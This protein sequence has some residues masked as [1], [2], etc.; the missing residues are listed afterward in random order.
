MS[1]RHA[2][3]IAT[4][5]AALLITTATTA[6]AADAPEPVAAGPACVTVPGDARSA[7]VADLA[8]ATG[9]SAGDAAVRIGWQNS[10]DQLDRSA[11]AAVGESAYGGLWIDSLTGRIKL[12]V[13]SHDRS[14]RLRSVAAGCGLADGVDIVKVGHSAATLDAAAAWLGKRLAGTTGFAAGID[15]AR[16][17]VELDAANRPWSAAERRLVSDARQTWGSAVVVRVVTGRAEPAACTSGN[18]CDP[19]LRGGIRMYSATA[20]CTAGFTARSRSDGLWYVLTAGHC[21]G[22]T[23]RTRFSNGT[24]HVIGPWHNGHFG[25]NGDAQ[26]IRVNNPSGWSPRPWVLVEASDD[27]TRDESYVISAVRGST[28]GQRI[29]KTGYAGSTDCGTV[30]RLGVTVNYSGTIVHGLGEA[31]FCVIPGD[32]GGPVYASHNAYGLVSGRVV[33]ASPCRSFYQ[34]AAGAQ[35]LMNVN[36]ATG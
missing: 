19:P 3:W 17:R 24:E 22:G 36:I 27:T 4:G 34:G 32:S 5:A 1:A 12:G 26:I 35:N 29:C 2:R 20:G 28:V 18:F 33:G 9:L 10:A 30:T 11:R 21:G 25:T 7:E 14:D 31:N 16:N 13:T 15:Y 8:R 6:L 23:W